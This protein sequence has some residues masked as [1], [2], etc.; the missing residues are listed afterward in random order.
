MAK[1]QEEPHV[2][3]W[4]NDPTEIIAVALGDVET[5]KGIGWSEHAIEFLD[6]ADMTVEHLAA[7]YMENYRHKTDKATEVSDPKVQ[8]STEKVVKERLSPLLYSESDVFWDKLVVGTHSARVSS[9]YAK[10]MSIS[11]TYRG[12][13]FVANDHSPI[14][15]SSDK[16]HLP[17]KTMTLFFS[18]IGQKSIERCE[19]VPLLK[20]RIEQIKKVFDQKLVEK[21]QHLQNYEIHPSVKQLIVPYSDGRLVSA[22]VLTSFL[23][24]VDAHNLSN[25]QRFAANSV[26]T[27]RALNNTQNSG[28]SARKSRFFIKMPSA[29]EDRLYSDRALSLTL[30]DEYA[31]KIRESMIKAIDR[32][33]ERI[34]AKKQTEANPLYAF[35]AS[36]ND[37][38]KVNMIVLQYVAMRHRHLVSVIN[39]I[40]QS[41]IDTKSEDLRLL[42]NND[43]VPAVFYENQS[44]RIFTDF[45]E[46]TKDIINAEEAKIIKQLVEGATHAIKW[47]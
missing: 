34:Q 23:L 44:N 22:T 10:P 21:S 40:K 45:F 29:N 41:D 18:D 9:H 15:V 30:S 32:W 26:G 14:F 8:K 1:E 31:A 17:S 38:K 19:E 28:Y 6:S 25:D 33:R 37:V 12:L 27:D 24:G 42:L 46:I 7:A 3:S 11:S 16:W 36:H 20:G 35:S 5:L 4:L 43:V 13:D 2:A 47:K 39:K